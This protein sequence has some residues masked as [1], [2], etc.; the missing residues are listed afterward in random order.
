[1]FIH[2]INVGELLQVLLRS[3]TSIIIAKGSTHY[4]CKG[5]HPLQMYVATSWL[6]VIIENIFMKNVF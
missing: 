2:G 5:L 3:A 1:M 6:G 4:Y